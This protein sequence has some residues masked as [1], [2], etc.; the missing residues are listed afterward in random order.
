MNIKN[1][2]TTKRC[3][4]LKKYSMTMICAIF[5]L[6]TMTVPAFAAVDASGF[7]SK[8]TTVLRTVI[9]LIGGGLSLWGVISLLEGYGND[10]PGAKSQ[11]IKQ[12][13]GGIGLIA[14]GMVLVP[15]LGSMMSGALS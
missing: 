1:L 9:F 6:L 2:I 4:K 15:V 12:L 7:V 13:M 5:A 14:V 3:H 10:N 8:A 11:G